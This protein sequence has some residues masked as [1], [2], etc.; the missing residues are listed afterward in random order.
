M[1]GTLLVYAHRDE[2]TDHPASH[3]WAEETLNSGGA[4]GVS[5]LVRR[6]FCAWSPL[7]KCVRV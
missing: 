6:A 3:D 7:R 1:D 4:Y 5:E 2:T